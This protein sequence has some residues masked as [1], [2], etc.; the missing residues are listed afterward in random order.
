VCAV[1]KQKIVESSNLAYIRS[2]WSQEVRA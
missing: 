2:A 1:D